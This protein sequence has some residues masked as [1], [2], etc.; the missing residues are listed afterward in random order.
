MRLRGLWGKR[1]REDSAKR[2]KKSKEGDVGEIEVGRRETEEVGGR[3][4]E[5]EGG[6][7][8]DL[9]ECERDKK[10]KW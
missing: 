6:R 2:R 10:G 9:G 5:R 3:W 4:M 1:A 7:K 8:E